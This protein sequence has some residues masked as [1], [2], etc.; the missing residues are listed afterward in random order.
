MSR[1]TGWARLLSLVLRDGAE[2]EPSMWSQPLGHHVE[3]DEPVVGT[4]EGLGTVVRCRSPGLPKV[5]SRAVGLTY[6]VRLVAAG[7]SGWL[8][9]SKASLRAVGRPASQ[10]PL[11]TREPG[12]QC[13][14][15]PAG[16]ILPRHQPACARRGPCG[17]GV[18]LGPEV[19]S[20]GTP[21]GPTGHR[22]L[23]RP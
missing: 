19:P 13:H 18:A 6:Q 5:E 20:A 4:V 7:G 15:I 2:R 17:Q 23:S 21:E 3:A 10:R 8:A 16:Q 12:S 22:G 1:R 9:R 11:T 14:P